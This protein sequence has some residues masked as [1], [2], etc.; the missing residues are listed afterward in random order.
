MHWSEWEFTFECKMTS[1][2]GEGLRLVDK[3]NGENFSLWKI[4]M[5]MIL[6]AKDL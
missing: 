6:S 3:F 2:D 1:S 4:K 5:E